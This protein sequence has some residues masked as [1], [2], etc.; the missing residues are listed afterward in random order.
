[1]KFS[2]QS[3]PLPFEVERGGLGGLVGPANTLLLCIIMKK[4]IR[5]KINNHV[6]IASQHSEHWCSEAVSH[7]HTMLRKK[8]AESTGNTFLQS[9]SF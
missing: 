2:K 4:T 5:I 8:Y 6:F 1:M 3:C 7:F 9:N